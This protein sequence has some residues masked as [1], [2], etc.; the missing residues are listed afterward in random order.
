MSLSGFLSFED[1]D[2]RVDEIGLLRRIQVLHVVE[3]TVFVVVRGLTRFGVCLFVLVDLDVVII[4]L[5]VAFIGQADLHTLVEERHLLE[6]GT[7]VFVREVGGLEDRRVRPEGH[8]RA[9]LGSLVATGELTRGHTLLE[10]H[11]PDVAIASDLDVK[12]FGQR[13]DH[14]RTHTVQTAGHSIAASAELTASVQNGQD[15]LDGGLALSGVHRHRHSSPVIDDSDSAVGEDRHLDVRAVSGHC[16]IDGVVDDFLNQVVETAF[17][18]RTD[19]H[20]RS[21]ANCFETLEY[22]NIPGIVM[23]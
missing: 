6:A 19:I 20:A 2:I 13:I 16:L 18:G 8:H 15:H 3:Q 14:C 12:T 22:R 1:D 9:G 4:D 21:L 10:V 5:N 11:V 7:Q 23:G 17:R